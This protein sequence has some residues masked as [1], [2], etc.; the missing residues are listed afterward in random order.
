MVSRRFDWCVVPAPLLSRLARELGLS[1]VPETAL[2]TAYGLGPRQDFVRDAWPTLRDVWLARHTPSRKR[3]VAEL[4]AKPLGDLT[5]SVRNRAQQLTY[6][7]SCRNTSA[8]REI[9]LAAFTDYGRPPVVEPRPGAGEPDPSEL[10]AQPEGDLDHDVEQAWASYTEWLGDALTD[11]R[12]DQLWVGIPAVHLGSAEDPKLLT[13]A[14]GITRRPDSTIVATVEASVSFGSI[15][16]GYAGHDDVLTGLGWT[17]TSAGFRLRGPASGSEHLAGVLTRTIRSFGAIHPAFLQRTG[18]WPGD[19]EAEADSD[20]ESEGYVADA[21]DR[22]T[23]YEITSA[24]HLRE[25]VSDALVPMLGHAPVEDDDGDLCIDLGGA[26][27]YLRVGQDG[28]YVTVFMTV[29]DE[30]E[31]TKRSFERVNRLN[32][33]HRI[34]RFT[35]E[36]GTVVATMDLWC[37]PF[38]PLLLRQG[39]EGMGIIAGELEELREQLGVSS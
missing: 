29:A 37:W 26:V 1:G 17:R 13:V 25:L 23:V 3:V 20:E 19:D 11:C 31:M 21:A 38:V 6:L 7:A 28:A 15:T 2:R 4:R 10:S 8:L 14:L 34:A 32:R 18:V 12:G 33:T 5:L 22:V 16:L 35:L 9:V 27:C 30:V 36:R 24:E 39:V